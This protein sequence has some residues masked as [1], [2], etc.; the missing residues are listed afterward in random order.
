LIQY[1]RGPAIYRGWL[2]LLH[3]PDRSPH[4]AAGGRLKVVGASDLERGCFR[5]YR[6]DAGA[7]LLGDRLVHATYGRIGSRGRAVRQVAGDEAG[8]RKIVP[9]CLRRRAT[10]PRQISIGT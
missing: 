8:A 3:W 5:A 6:I 2:A 4:P 1:V 7:D 10:A 9:R